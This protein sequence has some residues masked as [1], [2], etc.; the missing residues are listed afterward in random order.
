MKSMVRLIAVVSL[1]F[2]VP[3]AGAE[4]I[5]GDEDGVT[6]VNPELA[7]QLESLRGAAAL[8]SRLM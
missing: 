3:W 5:A 4:E 6:V 7:R 1:L 8:A 2:A